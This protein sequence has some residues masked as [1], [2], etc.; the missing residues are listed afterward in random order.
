MN[1]CKK[2]SSFLI[3]AT[4]LMAI[5]LH[6]KTVD[7][8]TCRNEAGEP[9][10]WFIV[11]KIPLLQKET[12]K[13]LTTGYSYAFISGPR[14]E[15]GSGSLMHSFFRPKES[16]RQQQDS[17]ELS[18]RLITDSSSIFG[19]TLAPLYTESGKHSV[20]MYN[21]QPPVASGESVIRHFL[22]SQWV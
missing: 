15:P 22:M 16:R 2:M 12:F 21:D 7:S 4:I 10:D 11:Y 3:L 6:E 13:P 8:L 18:D 5:L 19:Q 1:N 20:I 14:L 17:W 9:V